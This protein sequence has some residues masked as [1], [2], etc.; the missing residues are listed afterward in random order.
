MSA[1]A[2]TIAVRSADQK[3][4]LWK[5]NNSK[6]KPRV[7]DVSKDFRALALSLDGK[8]IALAF[9]N[10]IQ[11]WHREAHEKAPD[12]F[13]FA[14]RWRPGRAMAFHPT[15]KMLALSYA[16]G[17]IGFRA[18]DQPEM[19]PILQGHKTNYNVLTFSP[20]GMAVAAASIDG[21]ILY[22][23]FR[24]NSKEPIVFGKELGN[25]NQASA[26]AFS[27]DGQILASGH[28]DHTVRLWHLKVSDP[29]SC[30]DVLEGHTGS[31]RSVAFSPDGKA[32]ASAS[33]DRTIRLW[34]VNVY[35]KAPRTNN[36]EGH[37]GG[38]L[39][40][41]F[42]EEGKAL[43]SVGDDRTV[44]RWD[45]DTS[46]FYPKFLG[47][48]QH[49][50]S[51]MAFHPD[52]QAIDVASDDQQIWSWVLNPSESADQ[53]ELL[54]KKTWQREDQEWPMVF[55]PGLRTIVSWAPYQR[56]RLWRPSYHQ[57]FQVLGGYPGQP[58]ALAVS[59]DGQT[60]ASANADHMIQVWDL[61]APHVAR[62]SIKH[63]E[64]VTVMALSPGGQLVALTAGYD[65]EAEKPNPRIWLWYIHKS[66][67]EPNPLKDYDK[68]VL[69]LA[70][71]PNGETLASAGFDRRIRLWDIRKPEVSPRVIKEQGVEVS[72]LAF[73]P[74]GE[75]LAAASVDRTI[76]LHLAKTS[77]LADLACQRVVRNMTQVEWDR[78]VGADFRYERT[79][80]A[81]PEHERVE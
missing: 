30:F 79:C 53:P 75:T 81:L 12:A 33:Q 42:R 77:R 22:W 67:V 69:A 41:A 29:A 25:Q 28:I 39:A 35:D 14:K 3:I 73:S 5:I 56:I 20:D 70:F 8:L 55:S 2:S 16:N 34:P 7:F 43:I 6:P 10:T 24:R 58:V 61:D 62:H 51:A 78:F 31:V 50:I 47:T 63:H 60:V 52:G 26:L 23:D 37:E 48:H 72:A 46:K 36:L 57:D 21:K 17:N 71:S 18:L 49:L 27:P 9:K 4:R 54:S 40:I 45:L 32:I 1:D 64:P 66:K 80:E 76:R 68:E 65:P 11:R 74:D 19:T 13:E 44:R 59:P 15:R 38:V